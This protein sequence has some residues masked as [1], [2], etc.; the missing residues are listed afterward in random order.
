M[1]RGQIHLGRRIRVLFVFFICFSVILLSRLVEIQVFDGQEL[2]NIA[3]KQRVKRVPVIPRRGFITDRNGEVLALNISLRSVEAVPY[4]L[5]DK[6]KV[7]RVM[8]LYLGVNENALL[9]RLTQAKHYVLVKRRVHE[10]KAQALMES[11]KLL[12]LNS[13]KS[14]GVGVFAED[15]RFYPKGVLASQVLGFAGVDSMG[16]SGVELSYN[17]DLRGK[18]ST[19]FAERDARGML[20]PVSVNSQPTVEEGKNIRLTLDSQIQFIVEKELDR[21]M[22]AFA[23]RRAIAIVMNPGTGEILA[24][25]SRPAFDPNNFLDFPDKVWSN[26]AISFLHEPGST[27]KAFVAAAWI[28]SRPDFMKRFYCK[29]K[30]TFTHKKDKDQKYV[31]HDADAENHQ[32]GHGFL[33]LQGILKYSCNI[34][35]AQI[36]IQLGRND[37]ARYVEGFGFGKETHLGLEGEEKGSV[38]PKDGWSS[39]VLAHSAIG[40]GIAVTPIQMLTAFCAIANGGTLMQP[41]LLK[42]V[43]TPDGRVV[44]VMNPSPVRNVISQKTAKI[45]ST[46]MERV[47][48]EG[49]GK[50]AKVFGYRVAGKTGTAQKSAPRGG[51]IPGKF[52]ASF[53]GFVPADDPKI[54]ILV[55]VDEPRG[56]IY[57]SQVAAPA[58]SNIARDVL[59]ALGVSSSS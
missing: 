41:Y 8:S 57:G 11:L 31:L 59:Y 46:Y 25:G 37:F 45:L 39:T 16:L 30:L 20:I 36:G 50:N 58:F 49:T 22:G 52:V 29:G 14:P 17:N 3:R 27:F 55:E 1:G 9:Q 15:K 18:V 21:L 53:I 38:V 42:E 43:R 48:L 35:A 40:Q 34:G 23:P 7:A 47:V 2:F 19:V 44:K 13:P 56:S 24:M 4:R 51:Y 6:A 26:P 12:N 5:T 54:A 33:D 10:E 28:D 32:G